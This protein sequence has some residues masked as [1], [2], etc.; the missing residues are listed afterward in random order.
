VLL[1]D[2][3][4]KGVTYL[5]LV[6][7]SQGFYA[8]INIFRDY[9]TSIDCK[10]SSAFVML[11][12]MDP[13]TPAPAPSGQDPYHFIMNEPHTPKKGLLPSPNHSS[14]KSRILIALG[15]GTILVIVAILFSSLV[16]GNKDKNAQ[17][18]ISL[19]AQQQ[20]IVRVSDL[21]LK[22]ATDSSTKAYAETVK[23]SVATQQAELTTYL[24]KQKQKITPLQIAAKKDVK[25][26]AALEAA[27]KNNRFDDTYMEI[28]KEDLTTYQA[29]LESS[30]NAASTPTAK[31]ILKNGFTSTANLLK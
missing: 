27:L 8:S 19:V 31:T 7:I 23:L 6:C 16:L 1:L 30:Y 20:E 3:H 11:I 25:T 12:L 24:T 13:Y 2:N 21:A 26:D 15:L 5:G 10:D 28:I 18:L 14:L 22:S 17:S 4:H 9:H 29:S